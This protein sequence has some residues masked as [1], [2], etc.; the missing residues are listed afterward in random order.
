MDIIYI[1]LLVLLIVI[2]I[3]LAMYNKLIRLLNKVK[4]SEAGIDI[5]LNQRFDLIPNLVE[6]VKGYSNHESSTLE[7]IVNLRNNYN[8]TSGLNI[9][10]ANEI[11]N[12]LNKI[13]AIAEA[14]PELKASEQYLNLQTNLAEI[15]T[16]LE[17]ARNN[18]NNDVT[19][20]NIATESVPTNIIA[21]MFNFKKKEL[22]KIDNNR[23]ENVKLEF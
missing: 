8:K 22:F 19:N 5:Y 16:K 13:L 6:C 4:K 7:E 9:R 1:I 10:Q 20:Y 21:S 15:E 3:I 23:R 2:F 14:Y 12:D 18:Y 11:N 17:Y